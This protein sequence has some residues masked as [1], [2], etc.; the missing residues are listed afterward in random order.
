MLVGTFFSDGDNKNCTNRQNLISEIRPR[1]FRFNFIFTEERFNK[2]RVSYKFN[3][4]TY[5]KHCALTIG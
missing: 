2:T 3:L 5:K 1:A 4:H